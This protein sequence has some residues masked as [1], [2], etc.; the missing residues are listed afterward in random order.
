MTLRTTLAALVVPVVLAAS[1][2]SASAQ[3]FVP[4]QGEGSVSLLYVDTFVKTHYLTTT[5]YDL[6]HIQ[7]HTL[8]V[9]MTY[10]L[11]DKVAISIGIPWVA[12]KYLGTG[13]VDIPNHIASIPHP[14][15]LFNAVNTLDDGAYHNTFQDF[16]F[17][18]RY[19]MVKGRGLAITPFVGSINPSHGYETFAHA[20]PGRD[21]NELRIGVSAA[22]M[23]DEQVPGLF[24][25]G[26][27]TYGIT[28]QV[29]D[30]G[31]NRSVVDLEAGYF[32]TPKLRVLGLG[33]GQITHGG[34]DA[35]IETAFDPVLFPV[36]DQ[37]TKDNFINLGGGVAYSLNDK[38]DVYGSVI[39]TVAVR[40]VHAI[41]YGVSVG[42][43]VG[44]SARRAK[45]RA[46]ASADDSL[47][48]CLC[49]KGMK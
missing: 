46:I 13:V 11:T 30:I 47:A 27:Y 23:L 1:A 5:P 40:N 38:I 33:S 21:L 10:G 18:V 9:D 2:S 14:Q 43:S 34:I 22:K 25:Q 45:D 41:D 7:S 24:V 28:Q 42:F 32:V 29:L 48:R 19:N 44:F 26:S 36:H 31:H 35:T 4:E 16:R 17:N 3:A 49:E 12:S 37:I 8:L 20:A 39:H 15:P 6:G